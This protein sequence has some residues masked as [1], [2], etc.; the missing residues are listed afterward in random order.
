MFTCGMVAGRPCSKWSSEWSYA[1]RKGLRSGSWPRPRSLQQ[2]TEG[3]LFRSGM[4]VLTDSARSAVLRDGQIIITLESGS[5]IRFPVAEN[6]RL[7]PGTRGAVEPDGDFTVWHSLARVGRGPFV[8]R[9]VKRR[10]RAASERRTRRRR[11]RE[12]ADSLT[13]AYERHGQRALVAAL[14]PWGR[15]PIRGFCRRAGGGKG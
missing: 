13:V 12:P 3:L 2:S 5:E 9:T 4:S 14:R 1:S 11:E 7:A 8:S 6:P 10:L 15:E